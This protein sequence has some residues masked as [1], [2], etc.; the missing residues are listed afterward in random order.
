MLFRSCL[1]GD[2]FFRK[3]PVSTELARQMLEALR[4][5]DTGFFVV[6]HSGVENIFD[7]K[8]FLLE[9]RR[10]LMKEESQ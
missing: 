10:E 2:L 9:L 6:S 5:V 4:Q 7:K 8:S 1:I 3:P